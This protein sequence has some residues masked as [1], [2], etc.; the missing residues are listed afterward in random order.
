ME[1]RQIEKT[2]YDIVINGSLTAELDIYHGNLAG[3]LTVEVEF[4]SLE[5]AYDFKP[6]DWFGEE[7]TEDARYSNSY[8]AINGKF[9]KK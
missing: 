8:L 9:T 4:S 2:R 6:L 7:V 3:L 1:T 5:E